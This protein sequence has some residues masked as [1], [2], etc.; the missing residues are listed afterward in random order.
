MDS[1]VVRVSETFEERNTVVALILSRDHLFASLALDEGHRAVCIQVSL[2][3]LQFDAFVA[4]FAWSIQ[5]RASLS[6]FF[7]I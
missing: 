2:L 1:F 7:K 6:V 4:E 3:S 5:F